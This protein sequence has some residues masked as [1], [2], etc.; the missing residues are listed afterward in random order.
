MIPLTV[1]LLRGEKIHEGGGN[2][3]EHKF[4]DH[5]WPH[6]LFPAPISLPVGCA[7]RIALC[8]PVPSGLLEI[9]YRNHKNE[10]DAPGGMR[11]PQDA[12]MS[13]H[14]T[15]PEQMYPAGTILSCPADDCGRGLYKVVEPASFADLVIFDE[16]KLTRLNEGIPRR[17]VWEILACPFCGAQLLR[18]GKVHTLQ[19]GWR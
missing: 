11:L 3:A 7:S 5:E 1:P 18:D 2:G 13:M 19:Y 4:V 10:L 17:S 14:R 15:R 8:H 6:L 16:V 9:A 12:N